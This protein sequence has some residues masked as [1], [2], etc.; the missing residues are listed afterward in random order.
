MEN[1]IYVSITLERYEQ[2]IRSE[3]DAN[4]L[5]TLIA[6]KASGYEAIDHQ[7]V[8]SLNALYNGNQEVDE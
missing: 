8:S 2:L 7:I 1:E 5:K 3:H 4:Q 6:N